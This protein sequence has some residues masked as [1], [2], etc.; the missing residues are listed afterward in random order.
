MNIQIRKVKGARLTA[1]RLLREYLNEASE[2]P[3]KDDLIW[4][5]KDGPK[6]VGCGVLAVY[7]FF[8]VLNGGIVIP[9]YRGKG[10]QK[11][12]I[13]ARVR[14]CTKRGLSTVTFTDPDNPKSMRSLLAC[15]F[16]PYNPECRWSGEDKVYWMRP[17]RGY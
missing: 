10:I 11:R 5:A 8:G 17:M 12:L 14:E 16:K 2:A 4:L 6:V 15:G 7:P 1:M 3:E 9:E 13:R